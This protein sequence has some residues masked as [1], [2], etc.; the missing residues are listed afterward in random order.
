MQRQRLQYACGTNQG[1][2]PQRVR[3]I[4]LRA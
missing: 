2:S 1:I 3:V 4:T